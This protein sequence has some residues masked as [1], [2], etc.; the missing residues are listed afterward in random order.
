[1]FSARCQSLSRDFGPG[2]RVYLF[3]SPAFGFK[4]RSR[5]DVGGLKTCMSK[6]APNHR[7]VDFCCDKANCYGMTKRM[8]RNS[9]A[10][11]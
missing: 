7:H 11:Q 3:Q 5:V 10:G 6:P 1:M 4:I 2:G 9:F 8:R